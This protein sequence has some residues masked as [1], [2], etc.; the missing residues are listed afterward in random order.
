LLFTG[1]IHDLYW[2][3]AGCSLMLLYTGFYL[4]WHLYCPRS[5][6]SMALY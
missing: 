2:H 4:A 5:V 3:G 6:Y 1:I